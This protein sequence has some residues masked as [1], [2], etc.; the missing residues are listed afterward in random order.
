MKLS[1]KFIYL[2][3]LFLILSTDTMFLQMGVNTYKP[4]AVL[5]TLLPFL[6]LKEFSPFMRNWFY[7][8]VAYFVFLCLESFYDYNTPLKYLHVSSKIMICFS[9]FGV[10]GFYKR[11]GHQ[12]T[13]KGLIFFILLGFA[14]NAILINSRSFSLGAFLANDR[15]LASESVY[16][17]IIPLLYNLNSF[18]K[19][20]NLINM[21]SFFMLFGI[22]MFLQHR[23]VWISMG[24]ALVVNFIFLVR[25]D[26]RPQPTSFVLAGTFIAIVGVSVVSFVLSDDKVAERIQ[27]SIDQIMNPTG[28]EKAD[29]VSTSEWRMMQFE[30]YWPYVEENYL[31]GMRM[32]GYELPVQFYDQNGLNPFEDNTGHHFHSFYLDR[33]FYFGLIGLLMLIIP[34]FIYVFFCVSKLKTLS[35]EQLVLLSCISTALLFGLSYNWP[36]YFYGLLGYSIYILEQTQVIKS[37]KAFLNNTLHSESY[38]EKV[39]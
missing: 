24:F 15:G 19:T 9:I 8:Y 39:T 20:N 33:L 29:R 3:P 30:G 17:L 32:Q 4:V 11:F 12:T 2:I 18:M 22:I 36:E 23:T 38:L 16:L 13:I 5:F 27:V 1:L 14:L 37:D 31:L 21:L 6:F 10:Y 7:L 35:N 34:P 25:T 28:N 26:I